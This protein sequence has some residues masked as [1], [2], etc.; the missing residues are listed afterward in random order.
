MRKVVTFLVST[1]LA[2]A[3]IGCGGGGKGNILKETT[4]Q[5]QMTEEKE[6]DKKEPSVSESNQNEE[7]ILQTTDS[8]QNDKGLENGN[9][10]G[11]SSVLIAY[12]SVPEDVDISGIDA[13]AGASIVV[14]NGEKLGNTEYVAELIQETIGGDMFRIKTVESYPLNHDLLVEQAADEQ[15]EN[16]RPQLASHIENFDQYKTILLGYPYMEQGF[17]SVLCA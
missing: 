8:A 11:E 10:L 6:T 4:I 1:A 5:A 12:F 15:D 7:I 14:R 16:V 9:L 13:V 3:V 17:K 2:S